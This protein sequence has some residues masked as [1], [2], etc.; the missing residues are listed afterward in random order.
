MRD[1]PRPRR[2]EVRG[3]G[4]VGNSA[5]EG[6]GGFYRDIGSAVG[7]CGGSLAKLAR[8]LVVGRRA[9]GEEFLRKLSSAPFLEVVARVG[10]G[11]EGTRVRVDGLAPCAATK[12]EIGFVAQIIGADRPRLGIHADAHAWERLATACSLTAATLLVPKRVAEAQTYL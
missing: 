12:G 8:K 6:G 5:V 4:A 11:F 10:E 9:V 7:A 2:V 1:Q 3:R